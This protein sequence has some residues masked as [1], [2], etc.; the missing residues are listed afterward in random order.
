MKTTILIVDDDQ[1]HRTMLTTLVKVWGYTVD[2]ADDG[3][4]AVQKVHDKPYD[5]VIMDLTIPGGMGGKEAV[6]KLH[7]IHPEAR[8]IVSSGYAND[9]I[10]ENPRDY[11]FVD[12]LLKPVDIDDLANTLQRVLADTDTV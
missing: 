2:E 1:A 11:G 6:A 5:A 9:P 3:T 10:M 12:R 4:V 8:V 7:A